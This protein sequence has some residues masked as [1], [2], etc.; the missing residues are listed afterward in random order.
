MEIQG[1]VQMIKINWN[2]IEIG[3]EEVNWIELPQ[4]EV[5][6]SRLWYS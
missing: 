3:C 1:G 6:L 2:L 4:N 5:Q